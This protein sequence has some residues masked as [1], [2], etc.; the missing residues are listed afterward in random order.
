MK[1]KRKEELIHKST[2]L[3][4]EVYQ[5]AFSRVKERDAAQDIAQSVMETVI[6]KM[7][8]LEKEAALKQWILA[9]TTNKIRDHFRE[10]KKVQ[11]RRAT[12]M[13]PEDLE[14]LVQD[15]EEDILE[16]LTR[17]EAKKNLIAALLEL[18]E[19]YREVIKQHAIYEKTFREIAKESGV[20]CNTIRTR[21]GRGIVLLKEKFRDIEERGEGNGA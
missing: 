15:A 9:I 19:M 11:T 12:E 17:Q 6:R 3:Y 16:L 10:L 5:Y 14:D 1:Q 2:L 8:T 13:E 4:Q 20:N 21:Y 18:D 7:D